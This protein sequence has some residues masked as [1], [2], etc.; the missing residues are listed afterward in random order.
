MPPAKTS[1]DIYAGGPRKAPAATTKLTIVN[2]KQELAS[3]AAHLS[4][5]RMVAIVRAAEAGDCTVLFRVYLDA[6]YG[7]AHL[8]AEFSKRKLNV[9]GEAPVVVP[10]DGKN[11]ADLAA[12]DFCRDLLHATP[13][14]V[15]VCNHL[16][17]AALYPVALVERV[18]RPSATGFTL[19]ELVP[20]PH[21]LLD[22]RSGE[23]RVFDTDPT[24]QVLPTSHPADPA[25][26]V[27]HRGHLLTGPDQFGGPMRAL[28]W[29]WLLSSMD[30]TWWARF[31]ERFGSPFLLGRYDANDDASRS[32]LEA[33]FSLATRIGGLVV[34]RDTEVEIKEAA[35][36]GTGEAYKVF[37]ELCHREMSKLIV[38]QTL[39]AEAQSTGL[40]SGLANAQEGVREDIRKWDALI[41]GAAIRQQIFRPALQYAGLPGQPPHLNW[42]TLTPAEMKAFADLLGTLKTAGL[43]P[44]ED[45]L[46]DITARLNLPLER[47]LPPAPSLAPLS[48]DAPSVPPEPAVRA[49]DRIAAAAAAGLSRAF[50]GRYA[51]LPRII[52]ASADAQDCER[53][54]LDHLSGRPPAEVA[55]VI[56]TALTAFSANALA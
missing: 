27:I 30:R 28:L 31:L 45:G 51:E 34:T 26:Y 24:G 20:V 8:Q 9:L 40:G 3:L 33:A 15:G 36:A 23:L 50:R 21:R 42:G 12:A 44:T 1:T 49:G 46:A 6:I 48:A 7:S 52:R 55:D 37:I 41:L 56:E 11:A 4:A 10:V 38:G 32:V 53:R 19:A 14:W 18:Y 29:W 13:N 17:D 39:S 2:A 35:A 43:R 54:I 47:D 16:L 25:R 5:D 22:F